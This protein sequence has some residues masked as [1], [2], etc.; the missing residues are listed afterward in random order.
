MPCRRVERRCAHRLWSRPRSGLPVRQNGSTGLSRADRCSAG[1]RRPTRS[2][3]SGSCLAGNRT[4]SASQAACAVRIL[5]PL[6]VS[7]EAWCDAPGSPITERRTRP[8]DSDGPAP[9]SSLR[10]VTPRAGV[11][12]GV[13]SAFP[14]RACPGP[15]VRPP[16]AFTTRARRESNPQTPRDIARPRA[17]FARLSRQTCSAARNRALVR[18]PIRIACPVMDSNHLA[19]YRYQALYHSDS[20]ASGA[21]ARLSELSTLAVTRSRTGGSGLCILRVAVTPSP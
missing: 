15:L 19:P 7:Y 21:G 13:L 3:R 20:R 10:A 18:R 14:R 2:P 17:C 5:P 11:L 16:Q 6:S 1:G 9:H 8:P 12:A 4:Q